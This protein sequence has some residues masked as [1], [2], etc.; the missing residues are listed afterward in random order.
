MN[1]IGAGYGSAPSLSGWD[2][3]HNNSLFSSLE[4]GVWESGSYLKSRQITKGKEDKFGEELTD[5]NV[6]DK[7]FD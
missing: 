5:E 4:A 7:H 3:S 2:Y 1:L 6:E